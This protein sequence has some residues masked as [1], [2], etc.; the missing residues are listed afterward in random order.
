MN[1]QFLTCREAGE[2]LRVSESTIKRLANTGQLQSYRTPGGHRRILRQSITEWILKSNSE[3]SARALSTS[4]GS[5]DETT[6][7]SLA[8]AASPADLL[9]QILSDNYGEAFHH[10][11][12]FRLQLGVTAVL[13]QV[14]SPLMEEV[15]VRWAAGTMSVFQEHLVTDRVREY[16]HQLGAKLPKNE[17][18]VFKAVGSAPEGDLSDLASKCIELC[19]RELGWFAKSFGANLPATELVKGALEIQANVVWVSYSHAPEESQLKRDN[20]ILREQLPPHVRLV[21]GG[22]GLIGRY[23]KWISFDFAGDTLLHL[24]NYVMRHPLPQS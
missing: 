9:D 6:A 18:A 7:D 17:A 24:R 11:E 1:E 16:L 10:L 23:R 20:A 15:G 14:L 13:D 8:K 12:C 3:R 4:E 19:F 21:V 5:V 22:S 2:M